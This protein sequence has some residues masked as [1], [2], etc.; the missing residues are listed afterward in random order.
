MPRGPSQRL[1]G[2]HGVSWPVGKD[3]DQGDVYRTRPRNPRNSVASP[4][5]E[6]G[7][8]RE[9]LHISPLS[10]SYVAWRALPALPAILAHFHQPSPFLCPPLAPQVI[11]IAVRQIKTVSAA[12]SQSSLW[13]F[14]PGPIML[15]K[16]VFGPNF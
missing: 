13:R 11:L 7:E 4:G 10:P 9:R 15:A 8:E 5:I 6:S 14:L 12:P 3:L 2:S 16:D 1:E